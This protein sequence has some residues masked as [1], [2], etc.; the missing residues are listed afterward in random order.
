ME[1]AADKKEVYLLLLMVVVLWGINT[2]SIKYL[3]QFFPP[4]MLASIRMILASSFLFTVF[5]CKTKQRKLPKTAW[6]ATAGVAISC[7]FLHQIALTVGLKETSSTHATLILGLGPLFTTVLASFFLR[8]PFTL[9][10]GLGIFL[11]LCGIGLIVAGKSQSGSTLF[12]D[13]ITCIAAL[14]FAIGSLFVKKAVLN[15]SSLAV[16]AYSHTLAA[17]GLTSFN[18]LLYPVS[19]YAAVPMNGTILFVLLFSSFMS[20]A[21][22]ALLWNMSIHKVGASTA[23]LFQNA[24]PIFGIFAAA[25]FLGEALR[26]QYFFSLLLISGGVILGTGILSL[27]AS[28]D[29]KNL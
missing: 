23:A 26:W 19:D 3:T 9:A 15:S 27:P 16:T 25:L 18:L 1:K 4:I 29:K 17:I 8:E 5:L 14:T 28:H 2:V 22:G 11:G 21:V 6:G 20:T 12:G 7:I 24:S 13:G 10:K